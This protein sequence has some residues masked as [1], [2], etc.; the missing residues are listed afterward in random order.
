MGIRGDEDVDNLTWNEFFSTIVNIGVEVRLIAVLFSIY[1]SFI[2]SLVPKTK[3]M[4]QPFGIC[5]PIKRER[6]QTNFRMRKSNKR[7]A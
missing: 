3:E 7:V 1:H 4:F 2:H 5:H 6:S